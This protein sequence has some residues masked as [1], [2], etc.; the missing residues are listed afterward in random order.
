MYIKR[1]MGLLKGLEKRRINMKKILTFISIITIVGVLASCDKEEATT[2]P[3]PKTCEQMEPCKTALEYA[4]YTE[5]G[6][7]DKAYKME[8]KDENLT[9]YDNLAKAKEY[10][11]SDYNQYQHTKINKYGILE[12]EVSP[13]EKYIYKFKFN[14][15]R[16]GEIKTFTVGILKEGDKYLTY[17]YFNGASKSDVTISGEIVGHKRYYSSELT[18]QEKKELTPLLVEK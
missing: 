2:E 5:Q 13:N 1:R 9:S 18:Q 12:Y 7:E 11:A 14:D 6:A 17:Q 10:I 3:K 8:T 16:T 15:F 4:T